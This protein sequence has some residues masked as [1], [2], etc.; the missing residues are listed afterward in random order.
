MSYYL[1]L[2]HGRTPKDQKLDDW[3]SDGPYIGP[4][5]AITWTYG[6]LKLHVDDGFEFL[7]TKQEDDLIRHNDVWY[8]DFEI[9]THPDVTQ[10]PKEWEVVSF[11][12]FFGK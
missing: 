6:D 1:R 7:S 11:E 8:G 5:S 2:F 9:L 4:L 3:G 10:T 12:I